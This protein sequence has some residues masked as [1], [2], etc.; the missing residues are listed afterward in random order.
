M[1]SALVD[2]AITITTKGGLGLA[3]VSKDIRVIIFACFAFVILGPGLY[4]LCFGEPL[5]WVEK[6]NEGDLICAILT[7]GIFKFRRK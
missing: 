7:L 3:A 2:V 4:A 6:Y 1:F 5:S